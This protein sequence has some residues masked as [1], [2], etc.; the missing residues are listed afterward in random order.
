MNPSPVS[1]L[2]SLTLL[3]E[4]PSVPFAVPSEILPWVGR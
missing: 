4:L 3:R 2:T 1:P